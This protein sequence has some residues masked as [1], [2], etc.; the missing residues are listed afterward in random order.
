MLLPSDELT[1]ARWG[2][3]NMG[4]IL[5]NRPLVA[6]PAIVI[7]AIGGIGFAPVAALLIGIKTGV[8]LYRWLNDHSFQHAVPF[9]IRGRAWSPSR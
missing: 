8:A 9:L 1:V 5:L 2:K 7:L 6:F 4:S 3:V